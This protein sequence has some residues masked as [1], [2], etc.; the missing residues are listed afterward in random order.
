MVKSLFADQIRRKDIDGL[1]GGVLCRDAWATRPE[2]I[3]EPDRHIGCSGVEAGASGSG[4]G[5]DAGA[6]IMDANQQVPALLS[7]GKERRVLH[8]E[9]VESAFGKKRCVLLVC[10]G[11]ESIAE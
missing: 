5:G 8:V 6:V 3:F 7:V 1:C 2:Q 9:R 10:S 4:L 11:V